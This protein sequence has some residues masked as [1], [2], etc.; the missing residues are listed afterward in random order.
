MDIDDNAKIQIFSIIRP[1]VKSLGVTLTIVMHLEVVSIV[2]Q[3]EINERDLPAT[4]TLEIYTKAFS[5]R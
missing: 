1:I 4:L 3:S 2:E 5:G